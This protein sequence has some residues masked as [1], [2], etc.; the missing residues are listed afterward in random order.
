MGFSNHEL[1]ALAQLRLSQA[2]NQVGPP[3]DTA[4]S[5]IMIGD[6][7]DQEDIFA[8]LGGANPGNAFAIDLDLVASRSG[9]PRSLVDMFYNSLG[10]SS[11]AA[12]MMGA[13]GSDA[14]GPDLPL[15]ARR[16]QILRSSA[17]SAK[18]TTIATEGANQTTVGGPEKRRPRVRT[19]L[20]SS[21]SLIDD[22][23]PGSLLGGF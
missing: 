4:R 20:D 19:L 22:G 12:L 8:R 3:G 7:S 2:A 5:G 6:R 23:K 11:P 9:L 16:D 17:E 10:A 13:K 14:R 1:L 15:A 21:E 18:A